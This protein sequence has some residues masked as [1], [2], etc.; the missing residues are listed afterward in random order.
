MDV[1]PC[2]IFS[3]KSYLSLEFTDCTQFSLFI[4]F[5]D[6]TVD[7]SFSARDTYTRPLT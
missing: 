2:E 1:E 7:N 5:S 6:K 3:G 4:Y